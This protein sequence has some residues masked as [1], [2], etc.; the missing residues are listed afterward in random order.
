MLAL[1]TLWDEGPVIND[2][3]FMVVGDELSCPPYQWDSLPLLGERLS[4]CTFQ[5]KEGSGVAA[6]VSLRC[7][8]RIPDSGEVLYDGPLAFSRW[9]TFTPAPIPG[10]GGT[11]L[12]RH[13]ALPGRYRTGRA[14]SATRRASSGLVPRGCRSRRSILMPRCWPD[15]AN[16]LAFDPGLSRPLKEVAEQRGARRCSTSAG[17]R[18]RGQALS[19]A[20]ADP[21]LATL[22]DPAGERKIGW[23]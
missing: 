23:C 3:L 8:L 6:T 1:G 18:G 22:Q 15:P 7:A 16:R 14:S 5:V 21:A 11:G 17:C 13:P 4:I 9:T 10:A 2:T 19:Y 12:P 20:I